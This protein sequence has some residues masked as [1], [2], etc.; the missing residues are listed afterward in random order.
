MPI[1]AKIEQQKKNNNRYNL[2]LDINGIAEF[3]FGISDDTLVRFAL[4]KG[5]ELTEAEITNIQFDDLVSKSFRAAMN[6]ISYRLRSEKEIKTYLKEQDYEEEIIAESVTRLKH[7]GY[8]DDLKFA[9]AYVRNEMNVSGKGPSE[10]KKVLF[11]RG[12]SLQLQEEALKEYPVEL[13]FENA[14]K[15]VR[16][17][18]RKQR[19]SYRE[20][21]QKTFQFILNKGFSIE[22]AKSAI[23][24]YDEPDDNL[25][26]VNLCNSGYKYHR[27]YHHYDGFEY[28]QKMKK[29]LFSKGYQMDLIMKFLNHGKEAIENQELENE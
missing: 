2:Y 3:A 5:K 21:Y 12:I 15:W 20:A 24:E 25:E 9:Q 1:I 17:S 4:A 6:Y 7:Y 29:S 11:D 26:W 16:K 13:Q 10:I 18:F 19:T 27:K 23:S 22:Q 8:L 28:I 14:M